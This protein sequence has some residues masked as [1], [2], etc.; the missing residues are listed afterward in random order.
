MSYPARRLSQ[1]RVNAAHGKVL[2]VA[3]GS[4]LMVKVQAILSNTEETR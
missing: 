1:R 3:E 2:E 4:P